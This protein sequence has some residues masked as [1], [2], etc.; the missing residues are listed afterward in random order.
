MTGRPAAASAM[1][2]T[3]NE[4]DRTL[5]R[6][7]NLDAAQQLVYTK[8]YEQMAIQDVL[9]ELQMSKGAF[10]HYFDSKQALLEALIERMQQE[11]EQLLLPIVQDPH[12]DALEKFQRYIDAGRF[13]G[14]QRQTRQAGVQGRAQLLSRASGSFSSGTRMLT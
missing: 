14:S 6:S 8:G 9:N 3:V 11:A 2:R 4:Q 13:P 12:L 5:K 1:P 10:Y 7:E